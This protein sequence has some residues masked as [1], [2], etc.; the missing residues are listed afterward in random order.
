MNRKTFL[1]TLLLLPAGLRAAGSLVNV[2]KTPT[3]GC[4]GQWVAHM[5]ANGF[6][7]KV[8]D[9]DDTSPYR[10]KFG[11]PDKLQSCHTASVDGYAI[12]GHVPA[13]EIRRMLKER[14]N[15]K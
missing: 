4:C 14:P 9:V 8:Q 12:E 3:C 13:S 7:L 11:V 10:V 1:Q 15:A 6:E 2:Y 5:R